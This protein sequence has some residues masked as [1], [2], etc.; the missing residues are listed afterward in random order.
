MKLYVLAGFFGSIFGLVGQQCQF[1]YY[2]KKGGHY[3]FST[4]YQEDMHTLRDGVCEI[5][6]NGKIYE[7]VSDH[8]GVV[9]LVIVSP[10]DR[11]LILE[12][13]ETR[14]KFL[15]G[16]ISQ[17]DKSYL[18]HVLDYQKVISQR[19]ALLKFFA[20][21]HSFDR[22][23]LE[24]YD[25]QLEGLA[26]FIHKKRVAFMEEFQPIFATQYKAIS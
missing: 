25:M 5:S 20:A 8:I 22:T 19:N 14:I 6:E 9:P 10:A 17:A 1:S 3:L 13:S 23:T 26:T 24:V 7:K 4:Y 11:D 18:Q 15:D 12:G 16:V 21:N 2:N